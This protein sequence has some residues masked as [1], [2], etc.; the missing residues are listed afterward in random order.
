MRATA[1]R[2][3]RIN[4]L[5]SATQDNELQFRAA[6][7]AGAA[8]LVRDPLLGKW[9]AGHVPVYWAIGKEIAARL[10][11]T[12]GPCPVSGAG[13]GVVLTYHEG[14]PGWCLAMRCPSSRM[15]REIILWCPVLPAR[16]GRLSICVCCTSCPPPRSNDPQVY[17]AYNEGRQ[18]RW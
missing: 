17:M 18:A 4:A 14:S 3:L 10:D 9:Q 6:F 8:C 7:M 2:C 15:V 5:K 16:R 11:A 12:L 13:T 1:K